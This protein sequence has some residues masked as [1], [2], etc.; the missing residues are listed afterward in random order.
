MTAV[1]PAAASATITAATVTTPA[2]PAVLGFDYQGGLG[3][4]SVHVAGTT[5]STAPGTD[6]VDIRCYQ[7]T[8][9]QTMA[10]D[11]NVAPDGTFSAYPDPQNAS[12]EVCRIRAVPAST[13]PADLS[14][15]PGPRLYR[16][17]L[18]APERV[19]AGSPN[20]GVAYDA[21]ASTQQTTGYMDFYSLGSCGLDNSAVYDPA[22]DVVP[23]SLFACNDWLRRR[24]GDSGAT[25]TRSA[26]QIDSHDAFTANGAVNLNADGAGL[27]ALTFRSSRD[28][29]TGDLTIDESE[30]IVRCDVDTFPETAVN[31]PQFLGAGVSFRRHIVADHGAREATITDTWT[32]TDGHAHALDVLLDNVLSRSD[33][34]YRFPGEGAYATHEAGDNLP[35]FTSAPA[36]IYLRAKN[37]APDGNAT[38]P[39]GAV[40]F[41]TA[42]NFARI[43]QGPALST[44]AEFQLAYLRTIPAGGAFAMTTTYEN[45]PTLAEVQTL[46]HEAEDRQQAPSVS[47]TA[48][49]SAAKTSKPAVRISGVATDN[50]RVTGLTVGGAPVAVGLGGALLALRAAPA[51]REHHRRRRDGRCGQSHAGRRDGDLHEARGEA[52]RRVPG[53][54]APRPGAGGGP[55]GAHEG[56]LPGGGHGRG[57]DHGADVGQGARPLAPRQGRPH[58]ASGGAKAPGRDEGPALRGGPEAPEGDEEASLERRGGACDP[59]GSLSANR[60]IPPVTRRLRD[61]PG[62]RRGRPPCPGPGA[63]RRDPRTTGRSALRRAAVQG[64][65]HRPALDVLRDDRRRRPRGVGRHRALAPARRT[66]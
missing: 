36:S 25:S 32:S 49:S 66:I 29:V 30:D 52:H 35:G 7:G 16:S 38:D 59:S 47:I 53:A 10:T 50:A 3:P 41:S 11:V 33:A 21:Y 42:P 55:E 39:R 23:D 9:Y 27:P 19:G 51:R 1:A 13:D 57:S 34:G 28:P 54:Q 31:C 65:P 64:G 58:L 4:F 44:N 15:F 45:A 43:V 46:A 2:D 24:D 61:G 14:A 40:T 48:P 17:A 22:S 56:A 6:R 18:R 26:L 8:V 5:D 62:R 37:T 63:R 12:D 20:S 60:S